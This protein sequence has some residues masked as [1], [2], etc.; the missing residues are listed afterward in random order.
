M[1]RAAELNLPVKE[2]ER[3]VVSPKIQRD[4]PHVSIGNRKY[5]DAIEQPASCL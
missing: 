5:L 1:T 2:P 3:I 4:P